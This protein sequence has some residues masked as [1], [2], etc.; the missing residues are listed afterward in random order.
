MSRDYDDEDE[1]SWRGKNVHHYCPRCG[2]EWTG[3]GG[4]W[5]PKNG[6]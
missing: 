2:K 6:D 4:H 3:D 5:C 1:A